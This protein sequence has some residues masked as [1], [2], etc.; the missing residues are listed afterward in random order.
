MGGLDIKTNLVRLTAR[1][2]Y[3]IHLLLTKIYTGNVSLI[4]AF[5]M[6]SNKK[7]NKNRSSR[8]YEEAKK[9]V[10]MTMRAKVGTPE[11][12]RKMS[13]SKKG[14]DHWTGRK[15]KEESKLKQSKSAKTRKTTFENEQRRRSGI[16]KGNSK[17]VL[18][19]DL[20]DNVLQ[21]YNSVTEAAK[22]IKSQVGSIVHA[23]QRKRVKKHKGFKWKYK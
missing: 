4:Y 9:I 17:I 13:K 18:K 7:W 19:C 23:I 3:L 16:C 2:H 12:I 14:K 6:M 10:M 22:D 11:A 8:Y 21:E 20:N 15:H 5:W 1:E